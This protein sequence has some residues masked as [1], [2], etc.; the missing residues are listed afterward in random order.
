[1][2]VPQ[3]LIRVAEPE[4]VA[5]ELPSRFLFYPFKD[6]FIHPLRL[7]HLPKVAQ[8]RNDRSE[9]VLL[10]VISSI[11]STSHAEKKGTALAFDLT[12]EDY[13]YVLHWVR[14]QNFT[15]VSFVH[16]TYC[17]N[18]QHVA[19]VE[20]GEVDPSTLRIAESVTK[21]KLENIMLDRDFEVPVVSGGIRVRPRTMGALADAQEFPDRFKTHDFEWRQEIAQRLDLPFMAALEA[22]DQLSSKDIETVLGFDDHLGTY[23]IQ[24]KVRVRCRHCMTERETLTAMNPPMFL[25]VVDLDQVMSRK[26][27][28]AAE[29]KV[30]IPDTATAFDLWYLSDSAH[31]QREARRKAVQDGL[32]WHG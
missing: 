16:S 19:Q 1:M 2:Y 20:R 10:E 6:L 27:L 11:L 31:K 12:P 25:P 7:F 21:S 24:E 28:L 26:T 13:H 18:V 14:K 30:L 4:G 29:F 3:P 15:G 32:V 5:V 23:G 9:L 8:A 17:Q 22:V